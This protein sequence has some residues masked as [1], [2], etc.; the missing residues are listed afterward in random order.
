MP[1]IRVVAHFL[2]ASVIYA[3]VLGGVSLAVGETLRWSFTPGEDVTLLEAVLFIGLLLLASGVL[4]MAIVAGPM[5]LFLYRSH[6]VSYSTTMVVCT[7]AGLLPLMALTGDVRGMGAGA[8]S[9]AWFSD[10][11]VFFAFAG[12]C[13][14][15]Y[16]WLACFRH[17]TANLKGTR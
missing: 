2:A 6:S 12:A 3:V 5:V 8:E 15:L 10:L 7:I 4:G 11:Y 1:K 9:H 16:L 13:G 14:G 17:L